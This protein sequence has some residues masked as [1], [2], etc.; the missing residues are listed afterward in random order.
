MVPVPLW[1]VGYTVHG[2]TLRSDLGLLSPARFEV[3]GE[4]PTWYKD[5]GSQILGLWQKREM[6]S[7]TRILANS[8]EGLC[9]YLIYTWRGLHRHSVLSLEIPIYFSIGSTIMDL[10]GT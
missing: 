7:G 9:L 4:K 10:Q 5:S 3:T 2:A 8:R 6:A 1:L